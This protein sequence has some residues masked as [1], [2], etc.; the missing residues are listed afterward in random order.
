MHFI[1]MSYPGDLARTPDRWRWVWMDEQIA[2]LIHSTGLI[3]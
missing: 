2:R 1:D 3:E